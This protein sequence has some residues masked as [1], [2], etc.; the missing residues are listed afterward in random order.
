VVFFVVFFSL[1]FFFSA[2]PPPFQIAL[3]RAV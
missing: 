1:A 2:L 3:E